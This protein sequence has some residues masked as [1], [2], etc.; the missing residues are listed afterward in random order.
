MSLSPLVCC[1]CREEGELGNHIFIHCTFA[2]KMWRSFLLDLSFR[3]VMSESLVDL[4]YQKGG[5][6]RKIYFFMH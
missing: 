3:F 5:G 1:L 6:A 4:V 2:L